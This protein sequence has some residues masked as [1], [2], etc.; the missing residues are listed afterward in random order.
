M[1]RLMG[2]VLIMENDNW[3][4]SEMKIENTSSI[5]GWAPLDLGNV[6]VKSY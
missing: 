4:Y 2:G 1:K 6:N 3:Y 5:S